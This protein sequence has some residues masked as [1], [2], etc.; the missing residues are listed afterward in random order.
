MSTATSRNNKTPRLIG[1]ISIIAGAVMILGGGVTWGM[2][3]SQLSAENITIP[4]DADMFP[5]KQVKGPLTAYSQ[6]DIINKHALEGSGGKT[7]AELDQDDPARATVMNGSFLRASLFTS[8]IA[9]GVAAFAIGLGAL[10]VLVG[11]AI[12]ALA[13]PAVVETP[14]AAKA[15]EPAAAS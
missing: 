7:Y 4:G 12:R 9:F 5:G 11:L 8:V 14:G 3:Q 15:A 10:F 2:V 13:G 1:L 6:A